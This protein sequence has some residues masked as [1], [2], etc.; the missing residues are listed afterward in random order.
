MCDPFWHPWGTLLATKIGLFAL[1]VSILGFWP[2]K[3]LPGPPLGL[4]FDNFLITFRQLWEMFWRMPVSNKPTTAADWAK[5]G[6]AA[7]L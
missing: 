7:V 1:L 5:T 6:S 2:P 4:H 3:L